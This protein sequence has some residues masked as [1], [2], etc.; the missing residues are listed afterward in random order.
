LALE[1]ALAKVNWEQDFLRDRAAF[2]ANES[3]QS[4]GSDD[5]GLSGV[6]SVQR[7]C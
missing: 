7:M 5:S 4:E 3:N 6:Y 2:F 1:Q